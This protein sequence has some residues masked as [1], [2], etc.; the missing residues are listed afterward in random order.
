MMNMFHCKI[1]VNDG[2]GVSIVV[3]STQ[4]HKEDSEH[5]EPPKK[6]EDVELQALL[7]EDDS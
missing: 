6:F 2:F 1:R 7:A 3:T 4:D 5:R